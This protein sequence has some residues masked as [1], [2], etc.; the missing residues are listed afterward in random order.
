MLHKRNTT[1]CT[2]R[3]GAL[4]LV[5]LRIFGGMIV[6]FLNAFLVHS[7]MGWGF[8]F[9]AFYP[10]MFLCLGALYIVNAV[11]LFKKR[12]AFILLYLVTAL[13]FIMASAASGGFGFLVYAGMGNIGDCLSVPL[14]TCCRRI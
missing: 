3:D 5:A 9:P 12:H 13:V 8:D 4:L 14:Q 6:S 1:G 11:L 7:Y 2:V 10:V